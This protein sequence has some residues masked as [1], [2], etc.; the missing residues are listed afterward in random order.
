MMADLLKID[1]AAINPHLQG[2]PEGGIEGLA[3]ADAGDGHRECVEHC[4]LH[5]L[6]RLHGDCGLEEGGG[7]AEVAGDRV[8]MAFGLED[9]D[10]EG[11]VEEVAPLL[12]DLLAQRA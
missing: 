9:G 3:D 7:E 12:Q 10:R 8:E 4:G 1:G 11:D 6:D 5:P 2:L